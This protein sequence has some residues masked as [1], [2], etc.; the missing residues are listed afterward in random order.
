[1][2]QVTENIVK[3]IATYGLDVVAAIVIFIIGLIVAKAARN[4]TT[5]L[6]AKAQKIDDTL[7]SFFAGIVYYVVLA[8]V[9][10]AVLARFGIQTA[11]LIAVFGA[12]GLAIGLALQGTLSNIA[13]GVMLL[14]FRPFK[15][16]DFVEVAGIA[17]TVK[18]ISLFVTELAT[19]DNVQILAPNGQVWGAAVKNYSF[20]ATRRIDCVIGIAYE[21][22]IDT[23]FESAQAVVENS[24]LVLKDPAPMIVVSELGD[25]AV[26]LTV[27]VWCNASDYWALRFALN[28]LL[29][30]R[31]DADQISI[32]YP[33]RTIHI[34]N[35]GTLAADSASAQ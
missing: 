20:H 7:S 17:G 35:T 33:Q 11:S 24:P 13:A 25:S 10:T 6:C 18:T 19:A 1:M 15:A 30:E 14:L 28:K 34:N 32:P 29:K 22:N 12:A 9:I 21:D 26:N 8:F 23:A 5:R 16:G 3:A 4:L 2:E 27:R 31:F